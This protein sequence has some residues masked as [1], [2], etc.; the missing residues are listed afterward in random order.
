MTYYTMP[1]YGILSDFLN[2]I[3]H[4]NFNDIITCVLN[5][6][7]DLQGYILWG[8]C[9]SVCS[10]DFTV[11]EERGLCLV[12]EAWQLISV[13]AVQTNYT[14]PLLSGL[15]SCCPFLREI[16]LGALVHFT[17]IHYWAEG[18]CASSNRKSLLV[19]LD[20]TPLKSFLS[21]LFHVN[22]F[23]YHCVSGTV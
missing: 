13:A 3:I 1:C 17:V 7:N 8:G 14:S 16:F 20:N 18:I 22:S 10:R 6:W 15:P 12:I 23:K 9:L 19:L 2:G 11:W 4:I 5:E 21:S